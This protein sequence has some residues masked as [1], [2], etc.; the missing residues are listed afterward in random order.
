MTAEEEDSHR[1]DITPTLREAH[2]ALSEGNRALARRLARECIRRAPEDERG[3]LYLAAVSE[4]RS[5]I[6][7]A[8]RALELN[9]ESTNAREA[10]RWL[11]QQPSGK[12]GATSYAGPRIPPQRGPFI[13]PLER[14]SRWSP[15]SP[16]ALIPA[17]A[18][19]FGLVFWYG[20]LPVDAGN[21]RSDVA[22]VAKASHTPTATYT[23]TP[24]ITPTP[25][26]TP[27][28]TATATA[29]PTS[30]PTATPTPRPNVSWE[31]TLNPEALADEGR[32]IDVDISEQRVTAYEGAEPVRSFIVSTGTAVHPTVTGQFRIYV[33][34]RATDMSG[35]GYYLPGVPYTM[36]FYRGYALHGTYWHNNFGTPMSHGCVNL[37]IDNSAWLFDFA[38]VG[39]LVNVHP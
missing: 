15:L 22:P 10:I 14:L 2:Q 17:L 4:P 9:P 32:W 35:P 16:Q 20:N 38:S 28:D 5:A 30:T 24:T 18:L 27:T 37:T 11:A 36:Y 33:K 19:V 29:T 13:A 39:T 21:P 26:A 7:Y 12:G 25:T 6:A 23:P 8:K 1:N 31:Y 3:W 34:L